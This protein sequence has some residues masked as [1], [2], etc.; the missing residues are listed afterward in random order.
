MRALVKRIRQPVVA[1]GRGVGYA[2]AFHGSLLRDIDIIAAPWTAE[3]VAAEDLAKLVAET[4]DGFIRPYDAPRE[5]RLRRK[6]H[7]RRAF[8]IYVGGTYIDLSVMP[9]RARRAAAA[10][11]A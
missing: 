11:A 7:G 1:A 6:P 2:L 10:V 3:A 4:V 8:V 5:R 9:R